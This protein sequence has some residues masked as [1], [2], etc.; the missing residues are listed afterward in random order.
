MKPNRKQTPKPIPEPEEIPL[1]SQ[2]STYPK[3]ES[4]NEYVPWE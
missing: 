4:F 1:L 3:K 2:K